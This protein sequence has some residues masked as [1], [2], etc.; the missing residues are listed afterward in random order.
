[1]AERRLHQ[2]IHQSGTVTDRIFE[3]TFLDPGVQAYSLPFG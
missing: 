3:I 1:V 2:L